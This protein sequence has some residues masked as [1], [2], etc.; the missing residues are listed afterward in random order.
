MHRQLHSPEHAARPTVTNST[1]ADVHPDGTEW[2]S[3]CTF[4]ESTWKWRRTGEVNAT[5]SRLDRSEDFF[6]LFRLFRCT[7]MALWWWTLWFGWCCMCQD[8]KRNTEQSRLSRE[9][10]YVFLLHC[11]VGKRCEMSIRGV[12][13]L[14]LSFIGSLLHCPWRTKQKPP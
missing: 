8:P 13:P 12:W 11:G 4:C 1:P 14:D 7:F 9:L 6:L 3:Q 5:H 2:S 10:K